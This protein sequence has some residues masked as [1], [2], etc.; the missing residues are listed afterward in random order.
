MNYELYNY[1]MMFLTI[2]SYYFPNVC[3]GWP[4]SQLILEASFVQSIQIKFFFAGKGCISIDVLWL[5][6][7]LILEPFDIK[8]VRE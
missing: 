6:K 8:P 3:F 1:A 2:R 7:T 4:F 5:M